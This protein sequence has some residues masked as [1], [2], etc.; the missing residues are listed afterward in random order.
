MKQIFEQD[1][2]K[3]E[4]MEIEKEKIDPSKVVSFKEMMFDQPNWY[5]L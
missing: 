2:A 3:L 1:D 5:A 4:E